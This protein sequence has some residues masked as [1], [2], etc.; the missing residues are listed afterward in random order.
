MKTEI[1]DG[2]LVGDL[3]GGDDFDCV[4]AGLWVS[5]T[6]D[7]SFGIKDVSLV[8]EEVHASANHAEE[9]VLAVSLGEARNSEEF[10]LAVDFLGKDGAEREGDEC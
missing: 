8:A 4:F 7:S 6:A 2:R 5:G 1:K 9:E 10:F 3:V